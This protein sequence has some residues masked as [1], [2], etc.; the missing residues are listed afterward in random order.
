MTMQGIRADAPDEAARLAAAFRAEV[1]G[2]AGGAA[3][4]HVVTGHDAEAIER[5]LETGIVAHTET[6]LRIAPLLA[7]FGG[8][9]IAFGQVVYRY[10]DL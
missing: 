7:P 2:R 1:A 6:L 10:Q 9:A 8:V 4:G 3:R 5:L